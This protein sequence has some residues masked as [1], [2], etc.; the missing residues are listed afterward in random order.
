[1]KCYIIPTVVLEPE[2]IAIPC[3]TNNMRWTVSL[4]AIACEIVALGT[5]VKT[6]KNVMI[7]SSIIARKDRYKDKTRECLKMLHS[8]RN[9]LFVD[10]S[11]IYARAHKNYGGLQLNSRGQN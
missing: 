9:I 3:D 10:H 4:K 11:N 1:M 5:S 7:I 6:D 2:V 8:S